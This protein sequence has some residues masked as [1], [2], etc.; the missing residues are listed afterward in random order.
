MASAT[1]MLSLSQ[2]TLSLLEKGCTRDEI[3]SDL[4]EK[5]HDELFIQ[6]LVHETFKQRYAKMRSQGLAFI[7][8]GALI[9]LLSFA[10]TITSSITHFSFSFVLYGLTS[11]GILVMFAGL[12]KLF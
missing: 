4:L 9:C 5:G 1:E 6:G 2:Y 7:L 3:T 8:A 12:V 11:V 10:L